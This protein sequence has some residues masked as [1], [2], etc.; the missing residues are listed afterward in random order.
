MLKDFDV[1]IPSLPGYG[2]SARPAQVGINYR[3]V[4]ERWH[5]LMS[6]LGYSRYGAAGYDFGAG[7]STLLG[8]TIPN[9]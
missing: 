2:F 5:R 1:V 3:Y 6:E 9:P 4:A 8:L 7:V